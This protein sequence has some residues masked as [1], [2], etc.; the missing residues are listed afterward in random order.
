MFIRELIYYI[1]FLTN[2]TSNYTIHIIILLKIIEEII[3]N[4]GITTLKKRVRF[5][6]VTDRFI[7]I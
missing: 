7:F 4:Q 5:L 1:R 2:I 6:S 3:L